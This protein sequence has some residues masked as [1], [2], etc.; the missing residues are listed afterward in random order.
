MLQKPKAEEYPEFYAKYIALVAESNLLEVLKTQYHML[1]EQTKGL[2]DEQGKFRYADGKWSIKE[3]L[4][5]TADTERIM[6]YRMLRVARGDRTSLPG[7]DENLF[8][9]NASFDELTMEEL[10]EE[11]SIVRQATLSLLKTLPAYAWERSGLANGNEISARALAYII[12][13]HTQHHLNVLA[14]RYLPKL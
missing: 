10:H 12:A 9:E 4:G 5:H 1:N 13:G 3:L 6:C 8:V 14:E 11:L 2:S 7:F